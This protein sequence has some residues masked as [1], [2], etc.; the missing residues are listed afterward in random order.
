MKKWWYCAFAFLITQTAWSQEFKQGVEYE[1]LAKPLAVQTGEQIEVRELFWYRCPHCYTLEPYIHDWL[2]RKPENADYVPFPAVLSQSWELQ[3]R[4]FFTFEALGALDKLHMPFF[5]AIHKEN[6]NI[7]S[8][9]DLAKWAA[10]QGVEEQAVLDTYE[11]FAVD[12]K[13]RQAALLTREYGIT[14]VPAIIVDGKYR[15]SGS[16]AGGNERLFALIDHLVAKA[17]QE[18]Q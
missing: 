13:T 7:R 4:A 5:D 12:T 1:L 2:S 14:G 17:A 11:S 6:K 9:K 18:R 8:P 10:T 16:M 3:A 15:T